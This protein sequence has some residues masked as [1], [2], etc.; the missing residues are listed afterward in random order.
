MSNTNDTVQSPSGFE[1]VIRVISI[2]LIIGFAL[3]I[4]FFVVGYVGVAHMKIKTGLWLLWGF[5]YVLFLLVTPYI[6]IITIPGAGYMLWRLL[7]QRATRRVAVTAAI[8]ATMNL[9]A[10]LSISATGWAFN[11]HVQDIYGDI[12][13]ESRD[14]T[15][16]VLPNH[17]FLG[18]Q[19]GVPPISITALQGKPSVL[20]FWATYDIGWSPNF[21][22]ARKL[23][24]QR[25]Q[26][27][28]NVVPIAIDG[29]KEK[30]RKFL[31]KHPSN[32][33]VFHDP[34]GRYWDSLNVLGSGEAVVIVDSMSRVQTVLE[35]S[36]DLLDRIKAALGRIP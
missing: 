27:D 21:K 15:G 25:E 30:I 18:I 13:V 10:L 32:M 1:K 34:D 28:I 4:L 23:H 3:E 19:E 24:Q 22:V 36:S 29:S 26:L 16:E 7:K 12:A 31:Q 17:T 8:A 6:L 9:L 11:W 14:W 33:S 5:F 35:T 20:I 2:I